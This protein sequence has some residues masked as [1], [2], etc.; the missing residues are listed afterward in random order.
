MFKSCSHFFPRAALYYDCRKGKTPARPTPPFLQCFLSFTFSFILFFILHWR[1]P[2]FPFPP[3]GKQGVSHVCGKNM[4]ETILSQ[5][6]YNL[7][8]LCTR[9][10]GILSMSIREAAIP[11]RQPTD[12]LFLFFTPL[13]QICV[14]NGQ[15]AVVS[16]PPTRRRRFPV[17]R[18][19][20]AGR[21][22]PLHKR[23]QCGILKNRQE[24]D[25]LGVVEVWVV[26]ITAN[27]ALRAA[28][29]KRA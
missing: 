20:W 5:H 22:C 25:M 14:V 13:F 3:C 29:A 8:T 11:G 16:F 4:P 15:S 9:R 6:I 26:R 19:M 17:V 21:D 7:F 23:K 18:R 24:K 12:L 10:Q 2:C 1:A 27:P 28:A